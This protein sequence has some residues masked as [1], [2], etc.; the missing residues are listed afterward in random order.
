MTAKEILAK[1]K[2]VFNAP[3][4]PVQ[5]AEPSAEPVPTGVDCTLEDGR[6]MHCEPDMQVGAKCMIDGQPAPAGDYKLAD[7][8]ACTVDETGMITN[9]APAEPITQEPAPVPTFEERLAKLEEAIAKLIATPAPQPTGMAT[10]VQLQEAVAKIEKQDKVIEGLF[11][12]AE[13]LAE[14]PTTEPQTLTGNKKEQFE[15]K[16][17]KEKRIEGIGAAITQ[18]K[19]KK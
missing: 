19:N 15:R 1:V 9:V 11:A 13:K 16:L 12:L 5:A 7:G 8:S 17:S 3:I 6:I 4:A 10:E 18:L 14:T 2:S